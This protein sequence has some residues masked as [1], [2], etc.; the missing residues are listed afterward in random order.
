MQTKIGMSLWKTC[1]FLMSVKTNCGTTV[2][3]TGASTV[4]SPSLNSHCESLLWHG[5]QAIRWRSVEAAAFS[6]LLPQPKCEQWKRG[7]FVL[8]VSGLNGCQLCGSG[9][10]SRSTGPGVHMRELEHTHLQRELQVIHTHVGSLEQPI[11]LTSIPC[12][13]RSTSIFSIN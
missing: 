3:L 6:A 13:M 2:F 1:W 5:D 11:K 7:T 12:G 9:G 10:L 8:K 4:N